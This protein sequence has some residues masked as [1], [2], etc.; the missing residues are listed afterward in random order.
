MG[1][2]KPSPVQALT[3]PPALA[4]KDLVGISQT[5]SGKTAAFGLPLLNEIDI[6]NH[7]TQ[8]LVLCPTRELAVQVC[9]EIHRLSSHLKGL[10]AVPV[11]GGT[12][13]ERQIRHLRGGCHIVVGTP[14]R[15]IDHLNRGNLDLRNCRKIVLDEADRML[16]MGF[17]EEMETILE[18]MP[19]E[20]QSLFFSA[21]M[22]RQV[23]QIIKAHSD[24]PQL[25]QI[26]G[27]ARTVST[28]DQSYYEVRGRSKVEV[29][30]R[31][32]DMGEARLA[33]VFCNTKR[34]VDECTESL[35]A[36]GY[37][38]D[39]LHGDITQHL[40]ERVIDRC[41]KGKVEVLVAT[42]VAARGL[43]IDEVDVVF[44]FDLPYDPEDYVHRIGRTGR[45][46]RSGTA[47]SFV[48]GREVHRLRGIER[49]TRQTI[50]RERIPTQEQVEGLHSDRLFTTLQELL[51]SGK[52]QT[53]DN[54]IDRLLDQGHTPTDVASALFTLWRGESVR[55]GQSIIEDREPD[56]KERPR[57][58]R[59]DRRDRNDNRRDRDDRPPRE[60]RP[61][62][63]YSGKGG[64]TRLFL[65]LGKVF[66]VTPKALLGMIYGESKIPQGSIGRVQLFP[67]HT[68]V[69]VKSE[70]ADSLLAALSSAK[71]R[72][73]TFRSEIDQKIDQPKDSNS[74]PKKAKKPAEAEQ[75]ASEEKPTPQELPASAEPSALPE[76]PPQAE[77]QPEKDGE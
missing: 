74:A 26:K 36:R 68:L 8:A 27:Q 61:P 51:E 71:F 23:E 21:T 75:S 44:N 69:E 56:R 48:F 59:G 37:A 15:L 65:S 19:K 38:A 29:V 60:P 24:D 53:Y 10:Q 16:D 77:D 34:V 50:R 22:N 6:D 55:E 31:I 7:V 12:A 14:G 17:R 20:R 52:F 30:S 40:R 32:L 76:T 72:G 58:D 45:A 9:E 3:I 18:A 25:L 47:I 62:R 11:Y 41:R 67:K 39:R 49:Y 2:E 73:K 13:Y 28:V 64:Y 33:I 42:D 57:Q 43:D 54:D 5:G 46:G 66:G 70:H 35:L 1:F 4:G 63:D